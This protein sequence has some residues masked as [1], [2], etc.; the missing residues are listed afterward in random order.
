MNL[1]DTQDTIQLTGVFF[2]DSEDATGQDRL[3]ILDANWYVVG[4]TPAPGTPIDEGDALLSVVK[5]G[6]PG[7]C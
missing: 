7:P 6:E 4:Q 1:Q 2:S 5:Y 3:Q